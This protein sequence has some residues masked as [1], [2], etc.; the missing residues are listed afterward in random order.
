[1]QQSI[2]MTDEILMAYLEYIYI[3][4]IWYIIIIVLYYN[5]S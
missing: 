2:L 1:M 4:I 5:S 3:N